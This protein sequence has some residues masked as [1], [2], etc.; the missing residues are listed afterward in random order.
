MSLGVEHN[1]TL[2]I[3]GDVG[4]RIDSLF[5]AGCDDATFGSVDGAHYAV[6][7]R[8]APTFEEAVSS[9]IRDVEAVRGLRARLG[10]PD[11][12]QSFEEEE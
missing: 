1:F 9:A 11:R 6:F 3:E 2:A 12:L 8:A 10:D 4:P 7:E 5:R